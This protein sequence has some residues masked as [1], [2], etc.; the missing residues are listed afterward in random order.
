VRLPSSPP[1]APETRAVRAATS[2]KPPQR[3]QSV[4]SWSLARI[5][6]ARDQQMRGCFDAPVRL[7]EAMRTDDALFTAYQARVATQSAIA[8]AWQPSDTASNV[9]KSKA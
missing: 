5:R 1:S 3:R 2:L 7:A 8:L 9:R 4:H 6:D